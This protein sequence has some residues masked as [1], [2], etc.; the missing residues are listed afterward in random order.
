[1]YGLIFAL[2]GMAL[3]MSAVAIM[4]GFRAI[5]REIR[6]ADRH[7]GHDTLIFPDHEHD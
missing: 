6:E 5:A 3:F 7:F 2:A 1:M 4:D